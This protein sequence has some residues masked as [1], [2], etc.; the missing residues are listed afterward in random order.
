MQDLFHV[1]LVDMC[2]GS[3]YVVEISIVSGSLMQHFSVD[4]SLS[5]LSPACDYLLHLN[6]LD[7]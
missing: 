4:G 5:F 1:F 2:N 3:R 7:I 6:A